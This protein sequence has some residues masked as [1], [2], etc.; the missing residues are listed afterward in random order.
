MDN[1]YSSFSVVIVTEYT[2]V[3]P[4]YSTVFVT[5]YT[6]VHPTNV[7]ATTDVTHTSL[8][9][10]PN[11]TPD[12]SL[13]STA[14]GSQMMSAGSSASTILPVASALPET[15]GGEKFDDTFAYVI[16]G[17]ITLVAVLLLA[18]LIS[19]IYLRWRGKCPE[20]QAMRKQLERWESGEQKPITPAVVRQ[21]EAFN[22]SASQ[23]TAPAELDLER[24]DAG[25]AEQVFPAALSKI[26]AAKR[27]SIWKMTKRK[28]VPNTYT[29]ST[30]RNSACWPESRSAETQ[31]TDGS[32]LRV[33]A[34]MP[35]SPPKPYAAYVAD[36][37]HL[38][39]PDIRGQEIRDAEAAI[40]SE[41]Y[42]KAEAIMKRA[43]AADSVIRRATSIVNLADQRL[44]IAR[45][46]SMY[47]EFCRPKNEPEEYQMTEW[48]KRDSKPYDPDE[49]YTDS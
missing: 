36:E 22:K 34:D 35:V 28:P 23:A 14:A 49:L 31:Q 27:P 43:S 24:G 15:A 41:E 2:T 10:T 12:I 40:E 26:E 45:N 13:M 5:E 17:L 4:T 42:K 11:S 6:T 7:P 38:T 37:D 1:S 47:P 8:I 39:Y 19:M 20:C 3:H 18:M 21:R 33:F 44:N 9:S 48:R 32:E 30:N 16:L 25:E 46:P 29:P